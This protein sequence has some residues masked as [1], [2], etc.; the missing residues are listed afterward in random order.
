MKLQ[1]PA[2]PPEGRRYRN[3][4]C[5]PLIDSENVLIPGTRIAFILLSLMWIL[6]VTDCRLIWKIIYYLL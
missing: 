3:V 6:V 1:I 2:H 4:F 5:S